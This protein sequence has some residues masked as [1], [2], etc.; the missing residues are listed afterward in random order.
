MKSEIL[1]KVLNAHK[2][3]IVTGDV[4]SGK[5]TNVLF[6]I[7]KD[8]INKKE[9]L[10]I[11]DSREEYINK[12]YDKLKENDYNIVILNLRDMDKSEGWNP[13]EYPYNL[14][15]NGDV[16]KAQEYLEKIGKI[17]FYENPSVDPFWA[18]TASDFFTGV[19]LA[20]FEDG[21]Q[22]EINFNSINNMFNGINKKYG[23]SD[24][25]T[26][27]LKSKDVTSKPY[28]FAS[29]T[30][31]APKE[32]KGSILSVARQKL[33][34]YVSREKFSCLM[35]RTT[36]SWEDVVSKP[37][38]IILIA[39][40][41]NRSLNGLA[42]MFIEQLY[43][44]LLDRKAKVKFNFVLDNFDIIEKCNELVDILGSCLSRN[45]KV[46]LATRSMEK[47]SDEYGSYMLKLCDLI[48]IRNNDIKLVINNIEESTEK[49]FK[50]VSIND[51]QIDYP[52]LNVSTIKLFDI[53]KFV[54]NINTNELFSKYDNLDSNNPIG[55]DELVKKIDAR[56]EELEKQGKS[57]NEEK[58]K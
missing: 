53:E 16:D 9:S 49:E 39:R 29:T 55:I 40:D 15:K 35:N 24:Y 31:L 8:I 38:A 43:S 4:A 36:F 37:T 27:Y 11:L 7:A 51:A 50:A 12:Y 52:T 33:R 45:I 58:E 6:P 3:L 34:L 30:F 13:L 41:E 47:L 32:T 23:L 54:E 22:E 5:T 28:I 10:F 21:K 18:S 42:A 1:E 2:N 48:F 14:Y 25:I 26:T 19:A 56:I 17:V 20:L 44:I 57:Q 46:Y